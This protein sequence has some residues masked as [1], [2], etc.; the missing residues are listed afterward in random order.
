M[1]IANVNGVDLFYEQ[2]GSGEP[3]LFHHGYTGSHDSW[4]GIVE[5]LQDR[6]QCSVMDCRG[7]GDS[8]HP[9]DGYTIPQMAED[10]VG[11]AD[12]L[13]LDTFTFIGHSMG[14]VIGMQLG[15]EHAERLR[16]L[17][18]VAPAPAD[19]V[20]IP[21]E[22]RQEA[23][24]LWLNRDRDALIRRQRATSARDY[25]ADDIESQ[26]DRALSVSPGHYEGCWDALVD[27]R[28]GAELVN[29]TTPTLMMAG[30]AD[31]LLPAN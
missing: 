12:H 17:V 18:L 9:E 27:F 8:A 2:A 1:P 22:M 4:A 23:R 24:Q 28:R 10:V 11:M 26:V 15:L 19:G 25:R 20:Q 31:G 5:R 6:Y 3:L 7:A 30:A 16:K 21:E 14:G 29:L 13:G